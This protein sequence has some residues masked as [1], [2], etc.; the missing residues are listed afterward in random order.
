[1][2]LTITFTGRT[3]LVLHNPR[4]VDPMDPVV[5]AIA[6]INAKGA[7]KTDADHLEV[8]RLEWE[9]ALYLDAE[10]RLALPAFNLVACIREAAGLS[11][12]GLAV[13]RALA[14]K[15]ESYLVDIGGKLKRT[16]ANSWR[17]SIVNS[18]R[19]GGR[20]IR[21]R[22]RFHDWSIVLDAWLAEDELSLRDL[23]AA[24]DRAGRLVGL[25]DAR[26]LG[27][28]RFTPTVVAE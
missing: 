22:P 20:V 7:K 9:G 21:T 24:V 3:P 27:Y 15:H 25:G 23:K 17:T 5:R 14:P 12:K 28:G 13:V 26:K 18:G 6:E 8:G 10:G 4:L 19:S 11:R 2:D 16:D 1:M